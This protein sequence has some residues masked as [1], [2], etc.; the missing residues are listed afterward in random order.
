MNDTPAYISFIFRKINHHICSSYTSLPAEKKTNMGQAL[1]TF[2]SGSHE[3]K[4]KEIGPLIEQCY[5]EFIAKTEIEKMTLA[6]FYQAVCQTFEELNKKL[7][8]TQFRVPK[9]ETLRE[10]YDKHHQ[11]KGKALTKEE[12][13]R[14]LQ[15]VIFATGFTGFGAKDIIFYIF[16]VPATAL[17]LKQRIAPRAVPND[18]FIPAVTSATVFVLAKL[19]KI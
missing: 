13:Q 17:L 4:I 1:Q 6:E 8:S 16:G 2:A 5:G 10:A 14:I 3:K 7:G 9:T 18:V 12:F 19:N 11:L 15:D